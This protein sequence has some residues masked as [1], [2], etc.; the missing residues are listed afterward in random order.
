MAVDDNGVLVAVADNEVVRVDADG[1]VSRATAPGDVSE[2]LVLADGSVFVSGTS[3]SGVVT[4]GDRVA[5]VP[6]DVGVPQAA[7]AVGP[8]VGL[9]VGSTLSL[10]EL[11]GDGDVRVIRELQ[12]ADVERLAASPSGRHVLTASVAWDG[13]RHHLELEAIDM[14]SGE[15]GTVDSNEAGPDVLLA[16]DDD[17]RV[18]AAWGAR[19]PMR[20]LAHRLR[21]RATPV[22]LDLDA[23]LDRLV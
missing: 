12:V 8:H 5:L 21:P 18:V 2:V 14:S 10:L 11:A 6:A 9:L 19:S 7:V 16:I 3:G 4:F 20:V 23:L 15:R 17:G 13:E 22:E 1:A